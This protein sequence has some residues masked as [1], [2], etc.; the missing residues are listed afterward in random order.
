[1]IPG[2]Q[3]GGVRR[4]GDDSRPPK[5]LSQSKG[6]LTQQTGLCA[7]PS[8]AQAGA[9]GEMPAGLKRVAGSKLPAGLDSPPPSHQALVATREVAGWEK[10]GSQL[11]TGSL[12]PPVPWASSKGWGQDYDTAKGSGWFH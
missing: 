1:M 6:L 5:R 4:Q 11:G 7:P 10:R 12:S 9:V 2:S 8:P 3:N